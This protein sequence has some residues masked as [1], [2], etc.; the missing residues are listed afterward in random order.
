MRPA[1]KALDRLISKKRMQMIIATH[2]TCTPN[3]P[4]MSK[5]E[6]Q[7]S[8]HTRHSITVHLQHK[9]SENNQRHALLATRGGTYP[10][11]VKHNICASGDLL[12]HKVLGIVAN[13]VV[14]VKGV[15]AR[16]GGA[17]WRAWRDLRQILHHRLANV[18]NAVALQSRSCL[19]SEQ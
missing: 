10:D 7:T 6:D 13:R 4:R 9:E 18:T 15:A 19:A 12:S 2:V 1:H 3:T 16:G 11:A 5:T 8:F 17:V 14:L